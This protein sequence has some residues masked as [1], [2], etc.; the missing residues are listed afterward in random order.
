MKRSLIVT[1]LFTLHFLGTLGTHISLAQDA[2]VLP[3]GW[4][5][6]SHGN[7]AEPDYDVVFPQDKVNTITINISPEN[8]QMVQDNMTG[9]FGQ[10]GESQNGGFAGGANR[11]QPPAPGELPE[12]V[13]PGQEPPGGLPENFVPGQPLPEGLPEDFGPGQGAPDGAPGNFQPGRGGPGGFGG[14]G[15]GDFV[16]EDPIWVT[17]DVLF[18]GETWTNVGF[19]YKGNSTLIGAWG[20]G[21]LKIGFK[22]NFDKFEDDYPEIDD[23]RFYGFDEMNFTSNFRDES[24]LHEKVAADVFREAGIPSAQ[25]AFYAVYMDYGDGPIFAGLY[26]AVE[27]VED[28]LIDTQFSDGEGNLYKP[29]GVGASFQEGTF[30][31]ATFSKKTNEDEGDYRDILA[32]FDALHAPTR[33]TDPATWQA[34][35]ESVLDVDEFIHWLAVNTVIQNWDTYGSMSHNYY[36]Y[37]DPSTGLLTWIPWDNNEAFISGGG[38][39]GGPGGSGATLDHSRVDDNWPLIRYLLDVPEYEALYVSYVED[40]IEGAFN[41]AAME[42]TYTTL[43]AMI[44]PY[45][46]QEIGSTDAFNTA[47]AALIDQAYERS[48]A[49]QAYLTARSAG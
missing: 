49:A 8:W 17:V 34:N 20:S 45:V 12:G 27:A 13:E 14:A 38:G 6:Y 11:G 24:F 36:L 40:T 3:N 32:L 4:E 39:R 33:M 31:E 35:L 30:D 48:D 19:R 22:L 41:P 1:I 9:L 7:D 18:E 42:A 25:T 28:T 46:V 29:E 10:F 16:D 37:N 44:E 26:T 21:S 2:V 43:S 23:Q 15:G 47:V 5:E